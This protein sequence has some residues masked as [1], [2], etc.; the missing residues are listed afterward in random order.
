MCCDNI[1]VVFTLEG[2]TFEQPVFTA[3]PHSAEHSE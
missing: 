1:V 3:T 2:A